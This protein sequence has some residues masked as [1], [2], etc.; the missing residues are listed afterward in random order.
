M[1]NLGN[2]EKDP[3]TGKI[4]GVLYGVNMY[5]TKLIFEPEVSGKGDPYFRIYAQSQ[6]AT[7]EAGA[8]WNKTGKNGKP[9]IDVKLDSPGL[10]STFY[11]RLT[12]SEVVPNQYS[13][14]WSE[15]KPA[16]KAEAKDA[17]AETVSSKRQMIA[18]LTP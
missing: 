13:L 9:H 14:T 3:K 12:P 16:P 2:F 7:V 15:P 18:G 10:A 17:P 11:G 6:H 5:P 4:T 1:L 8:A